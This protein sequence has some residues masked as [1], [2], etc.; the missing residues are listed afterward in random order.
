LL[1]FSFLAERTVLPFAEPLAEL[2]CPIV[3]GCEIRADAVGVRS[4]VV[5]SVAVVVDVGKVSG[6]DNNQGMPYELFCLQRL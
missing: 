6:G 1:F 3:R 5:V 2:F 4:I